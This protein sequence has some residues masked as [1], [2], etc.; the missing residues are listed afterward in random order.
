MVSLAYFEPSRIPPEIAA[1]KGD[2]QQLGVGSPG[3][4]GGLKLDFS[5]EESG[6]TVLRGIWK[7]FPLQTLRA[8]YYDEAQPDL[9]FVYILNPGGGIL[10]GDR[11]RIDATLGKDC[12]VHLTTQAAN[13]IYKMNVGYATQVI[14]IRLGKGAYLEYLP[15][16]TIPFK[17]SRFY[18][19]VNVRMDDGT[20]LI[21]SEILTS[22]RSGREKFDFDIYYSRLTVTHNDRWPILTDTAV[23]QPKKQELTGLGMMNGYDALASMYIIDDRVTKRMAEEINERIIA[24]SDVLAG[25]DMLP[26]ANGVIARILGPNN[27]AVKATT[28]MIWDICRRE[29]IG[30]P[31]PRIRK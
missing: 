2:P 1:Y 26:L 9:A 29:L 20:T 30:S 22:G 16:Q 24:N 12:K 15:D 19:E 31:I 14:N 3:K 11:L 6:K 7:R 17:G 5:H 18:Q 4:L 25:A 10:Q 8:L 27:R 21:Y 13:K 28:D 23:L